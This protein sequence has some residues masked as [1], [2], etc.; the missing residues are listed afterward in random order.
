MNSKKRWC[1]LAEDKLQQL[2]NNF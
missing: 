2:F 1:S